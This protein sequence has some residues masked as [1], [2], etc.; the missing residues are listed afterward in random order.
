[1]AI[2]RPLKRS[3]KKLILS[4]CLAIFLPA[5][6]HAAG[7]KEIAPQRLY[8]LQKEGSG[9]WLIDV[10]GGQDFATAHSEGAVNIPLY[11]LANKHFPK[12]KILVVADSSLGQLQAQSAAT[13]LVKNGHER[14]FVLAGGINAWDRGGLPMAGT[15]RAWETVRLLPAELLRAIDKKVPLRIFDLREAAESQRGPVAGTESVP[16]K[17]PDEK[18]AA[19]QREL[20]KPKK[21][22]S[23]QLKKEPATVVILPTTADAKSLYQRYLWNLPSEVR[24]MEGGYLASQALREKKTVSNGEGCP[25]CPGK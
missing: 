1:M 6:L 19:V 21:S 10:R 25:T 7:W 12:G 22:L 24:V 20:E 13:V 8:D 14:V 23:Q 16:G 9:L 11:E 17:D 4:I 3:M 2:L 18:L 5:T 15:T